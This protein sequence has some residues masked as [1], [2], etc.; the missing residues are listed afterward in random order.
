MTT[1]SNL[2]SRLCFWLIFAAQ[3]WTLASGQ[4][5]HTVLMGVTGSFF[6]P[7][8]LS[9]ELGDIVTFVFGSGYHG[10]AQSSFE[11]PCLPLDGG[12]NSGLVS[13]LN[14]SQPIQS[15]N[16]IITNISAPIW[17]FCQATR[18]QSHCA[19]GMVGAI[20]PPSID[21]FNQFV[22]AAKAVNG[23][24][25]P[26]IG[27]TLTGVGAHATGPPSATPG[28]P[29]PSPPPS[30]PPS[31]TP[32]PSTSSSPIPA[33][34]KTPSSSSKV[35]PIV[36]G[37]IG[38]ITALSIIAVLLYLLRRAHLRLQQK[39]Y[40]D[41]AS[42]YKDP[43]V[44]PDL[45]RSDDQPHLTYAAVPLPQRSPSGYQYATLRPL[46][47]PPG[48]GVSE[49]TSLPQQ[50]QQMAQVDVVALAREVA[51]LIR[52]PQESSLPRSLAPSSDGTLAEGSP[53]RAHG[54]I[55]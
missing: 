15:W 30:P 23:T 53:K 37:V 46:P 6:D 41:S 22:S 20:N 16:L 49:S 38:G 28:A 21:M 26:S 55:L 18:P 52:S 48:H 24:P 7:A 51:T 31:T 39:Q 19:S 12:F 2:Q 10:A 36:G 3:L 8:V 13:A 1:F 32:T 4:T 33:A 5:N 35:G 43:V 45:L 9:A 17:Y 40:I 47:V 34:L 25:T 29:T 50:Q 14:A 54:P 11:S 44:S 42:V 27:V